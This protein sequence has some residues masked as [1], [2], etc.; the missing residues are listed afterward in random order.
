[1]H[2]FV[3]CLACAPFVF[4]PTPP[5]AL[6]TVSRP[7][8]AV[9]QASPPVSEGSLQALI[10]EAARYQTDDLRHTTWGLRYRLHRTDTKEDTV[11]DLV[12]S[13]DGHVGRTLEMRGQQ[14]T[15]D[16]NAA[17]QQRL[18]S[19]TPAD[20]ARRRR[21]EEGSEKYGAEMMSALPTAM[22]YTLTPGQPQLQQ[23]SSR[24]VVVDY[25]P[26]PAYHPT[27]V[28]ETLLPSL[29]GRMWIDAETHH[30]LR[31]EINITKNLNLA[32]GLL[33]RVYPG[34]T[35]TYEQRAVGGGHYAYSR[36]DIHVRL[37]ELMVKTVPY[38]SVITATDVALLPTLPSLKEAVDMLLSSPAANHP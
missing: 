8:V 19:L 32:M 2:W 34:G 21:G 4:A 24:Q 33:V 3:A 16:Q 26:D 30:L 36:I 27:T 23:F 29:A 18:R 15:A 6:A 12:E 22:K 11:R 1:M 17:E 37:R 31:I 5:T 7:V 38:D 28:A 10:R 25:V 20:L 13:R 9:S 14:L 35:M